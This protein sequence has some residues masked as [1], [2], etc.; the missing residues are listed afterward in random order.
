MPNTGHI[1]FV[2]PHKHSSEDVQ[3]LGASVFPPT[4]IATNDSPVISTT[5]VYA[6]LTGMDITATPPSGTPYGLWE[7]EITFTGSAAHDAA[8]GGQIGVRVVKGSGPTVIANTTFVN[9]ALSTGGGG[10]PVPMATRCTVVIS[11]AGERFRIQFANVTNTNNATMGANYR[12]EVVLRPYC[13]A[14]S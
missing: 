7:A 5:S 2:P 4:Q 3:G 10:A 11:T 1:D 9:C 12:M 13:P 14:A 8:G 6:T